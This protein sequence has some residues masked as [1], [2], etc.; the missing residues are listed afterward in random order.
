MSLKKVLPYALT[1]LIT[2]A[3]AC[4]G[5]DDD[6]T[7]GPTGDTLTSAE[8]SSML[9]AM[10]QVGLFAFSPGVIGGPPVS[11]GITAQ[12]QTIPVDETA[13]CPNGGT[14]RLAGNV[15]VGAA[16]QTSFTYDGNLTQT[17]TGCKA[18]GSDG[19]VFTFS[20]TPTYGIH[21]TFAQNSYDIDLSNGG[22]I[23]WALPSKN[24]T[25]GLNTNI[26]ATYNTSGQ[27]SGAITGSV[28]GQS[29]ND[30]F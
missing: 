16:S 18:A 25:C 15:A 17:F 6:D 30:T 22:T 12:T 2:M 7:T 3:T 9:D 13:P 14:V 20:G 28:C 26:S 4:G 24:G 5:D 10:A 27:Y 19:S 11:A 21:M 23:G 8:F 29:V 1:A